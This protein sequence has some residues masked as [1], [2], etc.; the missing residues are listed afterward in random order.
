MCGLS[1]TIDFLDSKSHIS[2]DKNYHLAMALSN[3]F[4]KWD[5]TMDL[6]TDEQGNIITKGDVIFCKKQPFVVREEGYIDYYSSG[7][8]DN[9][10]Q[11]PDST[12]VT[13]H[14]KVKSQNL[15]RGRSFIG[16]MLLSLMGN[17][18]PIERQVAIQKPLKESNETVATCCNNSLDGLY[19]NKNNVNEAKGPISMAES[20]AQNAKQL[21]VADFN[22]NCNEYFRELFYN[23]DIDNREIKLIIYF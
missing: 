18:K 3:K 10:F 13:L 5:S 21:V 14:E 9:I 23:V 22:E 1:I 19:I 11:A 2:H 20:D 15:E 12:F 6:Y 16:R 7:A 4:C 17:N 8:T